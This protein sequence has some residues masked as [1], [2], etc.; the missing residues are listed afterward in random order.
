[1][2]KWLSWICLMLFAAWLIPGA[3]ASEMTN[4]FDVSIFGRLPVSLNGR[5]QPFDSMARNA[6]LGMR[7]KSTVRLENGSALS[8]SEWAL[9]AMTKS[10]LADTRKI[11]RVQHPDLEGLLGAEKAGLEYYSFNDLAK[12]WPKLEAQVQNLA[13][14][15]GEEA[16]ANRTPYQKDLLHLYNSVTLYRQIKNSLIPEGNTNFSADVAA[17]QAA[18][19]PALEAIKK[20]DAGEAFDSEAVQKISPYFH[21]F[22]EMAAMAY[23]LAVP[24]KAGEPSGQWRNVGQSLIESIRSGEINPATMRLT[25]I[26]AAYAA[27]NPQAYGKSV[28]EYESWMRAN[29]QSQALEKA[30]REF[31][32]NRLEPFYIA[33]VIYVAALIL[34]CIVWINMSEGVRKAGV[35]LLIL[36]FV[37]HTLGL[38][39]R[40]WL[41][42]RPPVTNLYSSAVFI[43]WGTVLLGLILERI[44]KGAIGLVSSA[45]IGFSTLIIAH[46]LSMSGDTM[47]MLVAVLDTNF[48]LATHVVTVTIGYSSMFLAGLLAVMY[49]LGGFFTRRM[50]LPVSMASGA[51]PGDTLGAA[52]TRMVYGIICFSTFFSFVGTVLGGIWADQSWGRFWGWDPKENGALL[53]VIWNAMILHARWAGLIKERG[54]MAMAV[55]GNIVTSFSWFGVNM[56]GVG[57]HSYGFM[58]SAFPWLMAFIISQLAIIGIGSFPVRVWA[59]FKKPSA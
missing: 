27:N 32:F 5:I 45:A 4:Q 36:G 47:Q 6:L 17:F 59:S 23:P 43:G 46:H 44:Y 51:K 42:G 19:G 21:Q 11:F 30:R 39:F 3:R 9:E 8:A 34:G 40:M 31:L 50:A 49:I 18:L 20:Q 33:M 10:A 12:Q 54:L 15:D 2:K 26:G 29:D 24:P 13:N 41:E 58:D 38:G 55:F 22:Q 35:M 56:L 37:I 53:I 14:L 57:L 7:G 25:A 52:L 28:A 48:W 1:M 16:A